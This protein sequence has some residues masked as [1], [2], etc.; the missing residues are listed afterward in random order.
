MSFVKLCFFLLLRLTL[1]ADPQHAVESAIFTRS[2]GVVGLGDAIELNPEAVQNDP[3]STVSIP[4][5]DADGYQDRG[6]NAN[7]RVRYPPV[8]VYEWEKVSITAT[9]TIVKYIGTGLPKASPDSTYILSSNS[10][11]STGEFRKKNGVQYSAV[12]VPMLDTQGENAQNTTVIDVFVIFT[13]IFEWRAD[14]F[15]FLSHSRDSLSYII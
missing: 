9:S 11:N 3:P 2:S 1:A 4:N 12:T 15:K 6:C 14:T 10:E 13:S 5:K 8:T 7:C